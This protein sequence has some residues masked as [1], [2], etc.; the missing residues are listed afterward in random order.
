M[1]TMKAAP[2]VSRDGTVTVDGVKVG[3]V[4]R[5]REGTSIY[6]LIGGYDGPVK[7]IPRDVEGNKIMEPRDTRRDAARIV[8][9]HAEPLSVG[10]NRLNDQW[11]GEMWEGTVTFQ[12]NTLGVTRRDDETRWYVHFIWGAGAIIPRLSTSAGTR[13]A[14]SI[15]A[16]ARPDIVRA[17]NEAANEQG[18]SFSF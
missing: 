10:V 15:S 13:P 2:K 11:Y 1:P 7:W 17:L 14:D 18:A 3:S 4:E 9:V 8:A 5:T 6:S 16:E 12:G